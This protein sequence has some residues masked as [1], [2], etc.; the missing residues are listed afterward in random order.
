MNEQ[1]L[2]RVHK[3]FSDINTTVV[4]LTAFRDEISHK[5]NIINN[6]K[7]AQKIKSAGFGYFFV[8]GHFPENA[9]TENE[10][11]VSEDSIFCIADSLNSDKL[12]Q[13]THKLANEYNQDSII[14]KELNKGVYFLENSGEITE[15]SKTAKF[16][17]LGKYYTRLRGKSSSN[18][19]IFENEITGK[20]FMKSFREY[21]T[22]N[23]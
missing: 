16:N 23:S 9:D 21:V 11:D 4:I 20:G 6:K 3:H 19:F 10:V 5:E 1:S 15:L 22:N 8:D 2:S 13:L 18:T 17:K 7:I 14:V 12:I